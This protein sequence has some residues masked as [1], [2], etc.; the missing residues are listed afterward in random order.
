MTEERGMAMREQKSS[1]TPKTILIVD[2]EEGICGA[3]KDM[4]DGRGYNV[5]AAY[6]GVEGLKICAE[7]KIDLIVLDLNMPRMDGYMF[8]E[9][10][11]ERWALHGKIE[12]LPPVLV[13]SAVDPKS[14]LGLSENLGAQKFM[15]KP[16]K[17]LEFYE[18]IKSI[19]GE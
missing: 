4:L 13:L 12:P 7:K 11:R 2:D 3:M 17:G 14:D 5:L 19:L 8:L 1:K 18:A 16:F 9:K 15:H 6:D 10:L